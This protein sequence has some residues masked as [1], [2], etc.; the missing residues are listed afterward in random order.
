VS[1]A[2]RHANKGVAISEPAA[3][4]A[5]GS[6]GEQSRARY[7]DSDGFAERLG[8]RLFYEIYGDC[9]ETIFLL[10]TWSLVHSR[11]WKMQ[12]AYLAR[13][14]RVLVMDGLGNGRSDRCQDPSRYAP[15]EFARDCLSV[16]DASGTER[17]VMASLSTGAQYQL[18]LA[19]LARQRIAGAAFIGPM[20]PYTPGPMWAMTN[21]RLGGLVDAMFRRPA[22]VYRWWGRM[23]AVH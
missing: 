7:P 15:I 10:P 3:A 20:F 12:I 8:Q 21:D 17:A 4:G 5:L 14:F 1:V 23:N 16:M 18:A 9:E 22:P 6:A 2:L 13:H 11:H 19:E